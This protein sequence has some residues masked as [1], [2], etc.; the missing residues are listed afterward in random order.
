MPIGGSTFEIFYRSKT[1]GTQQAPLVLGPKPNIFYALFKENDVDFY[2]KVTNKLEDRTLRYCVD[3]LNEKKSFLVD[4]NFS[5]AL[6]TLTSNGNNFRFVRQSS[7]AGKKL[8]TTAASIHNLS[9]K[10]AST[11]ISQMKFQV[12]Y[13]KP[14]RSIWVQVKTL[15]EVR[16]KICLKFEMKT[17]DKV[18]TLKQL[19]VEEHGLQIQELKLE[20]ELINDDDQYLEA[21]AQRNCAVMFE[22]KCHKSIYLKTKRGKRIHFDIFPLETTKTLKVKIEQR[23]G[24]SVDRQTLL[25]NGVVLDRNERLL[26]RIRGEGETIS[27]IEDGITITLECPDNPSIF[28]NRKNK[29][30]AVTNGEIKVLK[31]DIHKALGIRPELQ[32]FKF[33]SFT[34]AD[35]MTFKWYDIKDGDTIH[36][37][38]TKYPVYVIGAR[39]KRYQLEVSPFHTIGHL[40]DQIEIKFGIPHVE[41]GLKF[42]KNSLDNNDLTVKECEIMFGDFLYLAAFKSGDMQIFVKTLTGQTI[43]LNVNFDATIEDVKLLIQNKVPIPPDEQ[44]LIFAGKQLE[45]GRTVRDY[46]IEVES[47]LHL[48]LCLRGG[49]GGSDNYLF[50][51]NNEESIVLPVGE[52]GAIGQG[53]KSNQKFIPASFDKDESIQIEEFIIEMRL[54]E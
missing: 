51:S 18:K 46:G 1:L 31:R 36:L 14:I 53:A 30:F 9:V 44:R 27:L 38:Y 26:Q 47:T 19:I 34:L 37:S 21:F 2:V 33:G 25:H 7:E 17:S 8:V 4:E 32:I 5:W 20:D 41:Q 15:I 42:K 24:I 52:R 12:N 22:M 28:L 35:E 45:V 29:F 13:S 23:T 50:G 49:G 11:L 6:E 43:T 10:E 39:C 40:K 3:V 48:V 54:I 16:Q